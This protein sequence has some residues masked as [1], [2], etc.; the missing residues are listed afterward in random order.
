MPFSVLIPARLDSV[1]LPEKAL[2][3]I[4][5]KP[6]VVR[7]A[8]RARQSAACRV[9]VATDHPRIASACAEHGVDCVMTAPNHPSGTARLA[10]AAALLGLA[11]DEI[12]VNVQGDEPMMPPALIGQVAATLARS[13][14]PIT[15]AACP[16]H[17]PAE[18][19]S[20]NAVKVVCGA[21]GHALY[22]S[23]APVPHPRDAAPDCP[24]APHRNLRLPRRF[25]ARIRFLERIAVGKH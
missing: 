9:V 10:E 4:G 6:M 8:E 2:A 23:R 14:A 12:V 15:T 21:D 19:A 7:V 22:F 18:F 11:D 20:P 5:G 1:R 13:R 17:D 24:P 25:F 3:N 16:I